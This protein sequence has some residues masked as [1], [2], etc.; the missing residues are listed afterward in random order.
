MAVRKFEKS[1]NGHGSGR[2]KFRYADS[3]RYVDLDMEDAN[4]EVADGIKSL[5]NALGANK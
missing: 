3:E 2:V 4:A 5:A 1:S